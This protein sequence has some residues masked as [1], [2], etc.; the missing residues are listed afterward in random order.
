MKPLVFPPIPTADRPLFSAI[1]PTIKQRIA[2]LDALR[3]ERALQNSSDTFQQITYLLPALLHYN[4]PDLPGY[5]PQAPCGI[6][7]FELNA[8]QAEYLSTFFTTLPEDERGSDYAFDGLYAMG[9]IGSI[10]QTSISDLDLW[11]CHSRDFSAAEQTRI[12]QKLAQ[13]RDWAMSLEVELNFYL[14]NPAAFKQKIYHSV[15]DDHNGSAQHF[16]LL[17]E[18]YRSAVRLAG[19]PILWLHVDNGKQ[20]YDSFINRLVEDGNLD[21]ND[22]VD[23][24]DFSSLPIEEYFG[25]SLWQLYKGTRK[26]YKSAIKILLLESYAETY[27][28]T[29]WIAKKFKQRIFSTKEVCYHFDPYLAMLEQVT[30][31]LTERKEFARLD[32]LRSCFYLKACEKQTDPIRLATLQALASE[33]QWREEDRLLLDNRAKWK[34]KQADQQQ[35]MIIGLLLQSY[36]NLIQFARKFHIDPSIMPQDVD[37]LMRKLYSVFEVVPGKVALIN[38]NIAADLSETQV[39]FIEVQ[40]GGAMKAGWYLLNHA[41][42][43]I[44]ESHNRYVQYQKS[45]TKLVAWAYFNRVV[46]A[47]TQIHLV[48]QSVSITK[49]RQFITDLRLN[50]PL[51]APKIEH[52]DLFYPNEIRHIAVAINLVNDPTKNQSLTKEEL[53]RLTLTAQS[54]IGSVS[55]I[56]RNMWNELQIKHLEGKEALLKTVKFLS[57]K[58]YRQSASPEA[59]NVFC[60][61]NQYCEVLRPFV[62]NLVQHCIALPTTG[63]YTK[64]ANSFTSK[65]KQWQNIFSE[66]NSSHFEQLAQSIVAFHSGRNVPEIIYTFASEGFLQFFFQDNDDGSFNVYILDK[67]NQLES[68]FHCSGLKEEKIQKI[69]RFY[70]KSL[71][72]QGSHL[73]AEFVESFNF[74]QFY[75]LLSQKGKMSIIPFQGKKPNNTYTSG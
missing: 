53:E 60:Y 4:L 57:N 25:A 2:A 74:P 10:T 24:G 39:T 51:H 38:Q 11:L 37:I 63:S 54:L 59:V 75:Q 62:T 50:F 69:T 73:D 67:Q 21:L 12:E 15:N 31:Y 28:E 30:G 33:W 49:L 23:F 1:L 27:P 41:P 7:Q 46:T 9:S 14:M 65:T 16:F 66:P 56:Y 32:R 72:A 44:Y 13:I 22:W 52:R 3:I 61:S 20:G 35:K 18:F 47:N 26:P 36:R 68:Y 19:K 6:A 64:Q 71:L 45:L 48:S 40:E 55:I 8:K 29:P 42:S 17:D 70:T 5:I 58:I 34:I 43:Q